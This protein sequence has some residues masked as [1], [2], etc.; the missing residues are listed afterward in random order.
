MKNRKKTMSIFLALLMMFS[1]VLTTSA[2][3][4]ES[5]SVYVDGK[6]VTSNAKQIDGEIYVPVKT[7]TE[8]LGAKAEVDS[9]GTIVRINSED[10][11]I[12]SV[13]AK[14]SPSVVGVIGRLK[15]TSIYYNTKDPSSNIAFGTGV[16]IRSNGYILTNAHVVSDLENILVVLSNSKSYKARLKAIDINSDLAMIKI[17]KGLLKPAD[18]GN[19]SDIQVGEPVVAIGTPLSLSLRNSATKGIVSGLNR[20]IQSEYKFIQSDAAINGGNSGGPLVNMQGK[21]IGINSV[22]YQGFGVEGLS[23]SIPVDTIKY[24]IDHFF[25]Y[26]KIVRPYLGVI[27]SEGLTAKFGLPTDEG[28]VINTVFKNTAAQKAGLKISD[29]VLSMNGVKITSLVDYNE[30]MKKYLP[31]DIVEFTISRNED[32]KIVKVTFDK[33]P[34]EYEYE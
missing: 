3:A 28:L 14:V 6:Q 26:G 11:S 18:L 10:D 17:D 15:K 27:F 2:G 30:E 12:S 16:I 8:N 9:S 1:F 31:G 21:V 32:T 7:I 24:A 4:D 25:K 29:E 23:F 19:V 13:I 20:S 22:K 33:M 5:I 34:E